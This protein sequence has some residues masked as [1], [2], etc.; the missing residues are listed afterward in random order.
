MGF[1]DDL[2]MG[3]G[4]KDR[5]D[6]YYDRTAQTLGRTQ[7]ADRETQYR[8]SMGLL[9]DNPATV[10]GGGLDK[11]GGLLPFIEGGG[12]IGAIARGITGGLG[13]G[14]SKVESG[15]NSQDLG[16]GGLQ[17]FLGTRGP[18]AQNELGNAQM[19]A[20][21]KDNLPGYFDPATR[22]YV[23]WYVDIFNGGGFNSA[24]GEAQEEVVKSR[25]TGVTTGGAPE[26]SPGLLQDPLEPFGGAGPTIPEDPL[27]PFGGAGPTI[28]QDPLGPF[29]GASPTIPEKLAMSSLTTPGTGWDN[30]IGQTREQPSVQPS[31]QMLSDSYY[32]RD[33]PAYPAQRYYDA[34]TD[35]IMGVY[36]LN[37]GGASDYGQ[38][39]VAPGGTI[40]P[41]D[42]ILTPEEIARRDAEAK[43]AQI[44]SGNFTFADLMRMANSGQLAQSNRQRLNQ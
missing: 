6:D 34:E 38:T 3:A 18:A 42:K 10:S 39:E 41:L 2:A 17:S 36:P 30:A 16:L 43:M 35:N 11:R 33:R 4:L 23:P 1:F 14:G 28:L 40:V 9:G 25:A 7:G 31:V 22:E 15:G 8:S 32:I 21:L 44:K 27:G 37:L 19:Q 20:T 26:Q 5:D 13:K 29:G 12:S 24:G